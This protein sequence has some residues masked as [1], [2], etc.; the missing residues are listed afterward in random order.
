MGVYPLR[1]ECSILVIP[2][3]MPKSVMSIRMHQGVERVPCG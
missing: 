1:M 3:D 2:H